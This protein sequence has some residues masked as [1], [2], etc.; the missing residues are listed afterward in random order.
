MSYIV[1]FTDKERKQRSIK[2]SDSVK[3]HKAFEIL[4]KQHPEQKHYFVKKLNLVRRPQK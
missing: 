2:F 3:A 4:Q 1:Y